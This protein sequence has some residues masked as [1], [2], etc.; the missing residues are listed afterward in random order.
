MT[1]A[2]EQMYNSKEKCKEIAQKFKELCDARGTTPYKVAIQA[3]LSTSTVSCFLSGKTI[4]RLDTM[5]MLC[6]ELGIPMTVFFDEKELTDHQVQEEQKIIEMY[7]S[8][9]AK[10]QEKLYEYLEMLMQYREP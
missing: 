6:N 8:L 5:L 1:K 9:P 3:G 10:K 4:P 7:R 2:V